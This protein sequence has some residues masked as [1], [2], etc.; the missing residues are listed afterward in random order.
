LRKSF[1]SEIEMSP[2]MDVAD[3]LDARHAPASCAFAEA[4]PASTVPTIA[5]TNF[6]RIIP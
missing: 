1:S 4:Q 2:V 6:S 3:E 5:H